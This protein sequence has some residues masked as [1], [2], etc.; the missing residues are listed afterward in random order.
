MEREQA[1]DEFIIN[2]NNTLGRYATTFELQRAIYDAGYE[3]GLSEGIPQ[4]T[5]DGYDAA[6]GQQQWVAI[7]SADDLPKGAG[8]VPR[9]LLQRSKLLT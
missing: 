6:A 3:A 2:A 8:R 1:R 9:R 5:L 7:E 4:G